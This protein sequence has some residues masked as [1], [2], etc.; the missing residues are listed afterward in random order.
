[1]QIPAENCIVTHIRKVFWV[2][3]DNRI[4]IVQL[5]FFYVRPAVWQY[6]IEWNI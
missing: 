2:V 1:M 3:K 6:L 4:N 5:Y